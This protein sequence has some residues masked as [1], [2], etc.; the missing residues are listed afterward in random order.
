VDGSPEMVEAEFPEAVLLKQ[1][2]NLGFAE[3]CNRGIDASRGSWVALL[4]NDA[5][6]EPG[7]ARALVDE[8]EKA[9]PNCGMLQ[10]LLLYQ[11]RPGVINSTG[12]EL[13]Y[14]GGGR[15]RDGGKLRQNSEPAADV[16]CPTGGAASYRRSMLD[17][18]K[19][20][21]QG[22]RSVVAASYFDPAHFMYYE[23]LDLGWRARLAGWT[24]QYVPQSVVLHRWHGSSDRHGASWLTVVSCTNR[25][26]TLLKNASLQFLVRT[27]PR[28]ILEVGKVVWFGRIAAMVRLARA[29]R[30]SMALRARVDSMARIPRRAI[31][32]RWTAAPS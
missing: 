32:R 6:A 26:R 30:D 14:S 11:D 21:R 16:F 8:A 20:P 22:L 24:A 15:D 3:G 31:E 25:L 17:S 1:S 4:N 9:P 2:E 27:S 12:I 5:T 13:T 10:S 28:T 19:L 18:I 23:D 7:W 29:V